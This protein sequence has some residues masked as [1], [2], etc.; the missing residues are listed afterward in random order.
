MG[1]SRESSLAG[2]RMGSTH[3]DSHLTNPVL[4]W[5]LPLFPTLSVLIWKRG[6]VMNWTIW[7]MGDNWRLAAP[8]DFRFAVFQGGF[9]TFRVTWEVGPFLK[10][11]YFI[12]QGFIIAI[13]FRVCKSSIWVIQ[14]EARDSG[15]GQQHKLVRFLVWLGITS[16]VVNGRVESRKCQ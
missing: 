14:D 7:F 11:K 10:G 4:S 6:S 1:N 16:G 13:W 9:S 2:G 5:K 8:Y 12:T 15:F 3:L